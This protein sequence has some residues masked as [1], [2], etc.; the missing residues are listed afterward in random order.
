MS[1]PEWLTP[2]ARLVETIRLEDFQAILPPDETEGRASAVLL[3]FWQDPEHGISVLLIERSA[4]LRSHAGQPAFPGGAVDPE[5]S[6]PVAAALRETVEETGLDPAGVEILGCLP[7]L[8]IPVSNFRVTPVLAWWRDPSPVHAV[9]AAE[10]ASVHAVRLADLVDADNRLRV[11]HVA[12]GRVMPAFAVNGMLVWGFTA[13]VLDHLIRLVGWERPWSRE[14]VVDL[15]DDAVA[16]ASRTDP[17]GG[18]GG[19]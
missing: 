10:V 9:D 4:E 7:D 18:E 1:H 19:A 11:R 16:M 12:S 8:F 6:G 15:S 17:S 3:L 14:R 2:L 5:D 13:G